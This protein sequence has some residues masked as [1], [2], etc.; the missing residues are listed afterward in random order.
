MAVSVTHATV[1]VGTNDGNGEIAKDEWNEAHSISMASQRVLGRTTSG[2]G[3]AE[4]L[5]GMWVEVS[6]ATASNSTSI[7]F[8]GIDS[9]A[10]EWM[11]EYYNVIPATSADWFFFRTSTDNGA[12][13]D[14]GASD[15]T[16]L[17]LTAAAGGASVYAY[18][19][20][21]GYIGAD[22][23]GRGTNQVGANGRTLITTPSVAQ[24]GV[25]RNQTCIQVTGGDLKLAD[26]FVVRNSAADITAIRHAFSTNNIASGTF[27][28]Y[29]RLK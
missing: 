13:Y 4:E 8:T 2:T 12:T 24:Y 22:D 3:A 23:V 25:I 5:K 7:D 21:E 18:T 14:S 1:A 15:Y 6:R 19:D 9:T 17:Q 26:N 28:L 20:P 27:V 29:K 10:D 11:V 16:G